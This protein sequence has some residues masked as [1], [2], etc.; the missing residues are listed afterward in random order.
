MGDLNP[1]GP[2]FVELAP[3]AIAAAVAT[4]AVASPRILW[5]IKSWLISAGA[6][7]AGCRISR[8]RVGPI[9]GILSRR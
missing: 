7:V 2:L 9:Q 5:L 3:L 1:F 6:V 4:G 8:G